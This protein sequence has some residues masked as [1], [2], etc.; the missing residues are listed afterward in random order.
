[1]TLMHLTID[2]RNVDIIKSYQK[3]HE[4]YP[5]PNGRGNGIFREKTLLRTH[6]KLS[7]VAICLQKYELI[8][9][10]KNTYN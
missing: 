3:Y 2:T 1:M 6:S 8:I 4:P 10:I 7:G 9:T 5:D